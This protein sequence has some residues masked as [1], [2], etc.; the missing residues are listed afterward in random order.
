MKNVDKKV[1]LT[2]VIVLNLE[3]AEKEYSVPDTQLAGLVLRVR[4]SGDKTW[5]IRT[6]DGRGKLRRVTL[7]KAIDLTPAQARAKGEAAKVDLRIS[8]VRNLSAGR[9]SPTLAQFFKVYLER[10]AIPNKRPRSVYDRV[11]EDLGYWNRCLRPLLGSFPVSTISHADVQE[12]LNQSREKP[13]QANRSLAL[14]RHMFTCWRRW[15]HNNDDP[16]RN[17]SGYRERPRDTYLSVPDVEKLFAAANSDPDRGAALVIKLALLTGASQ[18]G[19]ASESSA[20]CP[21]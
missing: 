8:R 11:Y 21:G 7:G 2:S 15:D 5:N 20:R 12:L 6:R 13:I 19:G 10:H 18:A 1:K 16:C 4:S 14:L 3:P 17:V 9:T